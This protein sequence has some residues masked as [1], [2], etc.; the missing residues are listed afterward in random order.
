MA[1][2]PKGSTNRA[3]GK[4]FELALRRSLARKHGTVDKGLEKIAAKLAGAGEKGEQW[5]VREIADRIDGKA[6]Q[7]I[8]GPNGGPLEVKV[9]RIER[10]I[11]RG[12]NSKA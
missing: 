3:D 5:A 1:G 4:L 12:K 10:V 9:T 6:T 2:A 11:V 8:S 7:P